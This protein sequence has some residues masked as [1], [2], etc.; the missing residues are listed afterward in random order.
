MKT[1]DKFLNKMTVKKHYLI[2]KDVEVLNVLNIV[3]Q[4]Q[5]SYISKDLAVS[6]CGWADENSDKW[7]IRFNSSIEQ[8]SSIVHELKK[9][10]DIMVKNEY[11]PEDLYLERRIES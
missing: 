10:F 11:R 2:L 9:D 5:S 8:W 4:H 3:N 7:Y 1:M 6:N